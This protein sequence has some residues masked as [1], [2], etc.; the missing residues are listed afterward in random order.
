MRRRLLSV[1]ARDCTPEGA[2]VLCG[3]RESCVWLKEGEPCVAK[4]RELCVAQHNKRRELCVAQH[5]KH[6]ELCVAQ[7]NK[8][9]ELCV[10]CR[11]RT[12]AC[13]YA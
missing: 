8:H 7:H 2:R 9:R 12:T 10:A 5:N 3:H 1:A 13:R 11:S 6:R 4:H